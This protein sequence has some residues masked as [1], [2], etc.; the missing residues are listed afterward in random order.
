MIPKSGLHRLSHQFSTLSATRSFSRS[1]RIS[2]VNHED[3]PRLLSLCGSEGNFHLG[4]SL[5]ASIFKNPDFNGLEDDINSRNSLFIWNSLLYAYVKWGGM[6]NACNLFDDMPLKDTVSWNTLI[7]G[8]LR[9]GEFR[10][11]I[12]LFKRMQEMSRID[13]ATITTILS[14]CDRSELC[15]ITRM[16][17]GVVCKSGYEKE[18]TVRNALITSYFRCGVFSSSGKQVFDEMCEKNVISWT[19]LISGLAK[20]NFFAESLN[21]F[22]KMRKGIVE[23]NSLTYLSSITAC[24]GL[25]A[26]IEGRQIHGIVLK[27]GF[28]SN[29]C[30]ESA[31]M[32]MYSK[33]G[34]V[35]DAWKIFEFAETLDEISITVI[36]VGFAQNGLEEEALQIFIKMLRAGIKIDSNV[37]S[38]IL[39]VFG[40][41]S[42]SLGLGSQIH[43]LIIKRSMAPNPFIS[44]GL[45]NMY[46]K[47]GHLDDSIKVFNRMHLRNSI[48]YN[49]MIASLARHGNGPGALELYDKMRLEAVNPT[50][51]TFLSLLH[52]CSHVGL[53]DK[54]MEFLDSMER[55]Y[56]IKPRAEHY[57]CIVDMLGRAGLLYEAKIFIEQRM[58]VNP[59]SLVWQSFLGA[60][61]IHKNSD[62]G[63]YAAKQLTKLS[64]ESPVPYILMAN[65]FSSEGKWK[66]RA[67]EIKAMKEMGAM[68][69][70]GISWIEIEKE[71]HS[72]V[73]YDRMH[74]QSESVFRVLKELWWL[75]KDEGYVPDKRFILYCL[76][77]EE[78]EEGE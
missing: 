74:P 66:D 2:V 17:H 67:M 27:L 26:M 23:P 21:F 37:V 45:I 55:D 24:S 19:A 25:Q 12:F 62:L 77:D 34:S 28:E 73:V 36:L 69:E 68:K 31:L 54:G 52:A 18:V 50:D 78:D 41:G 75:L 22:V 35:M 6:A 60:C 49:S 10:T 42:S 1:S 61:S 65:I 40:L 56:G 11:C 8:Y 57:A 76:Q 47:C 44:N 43:A 70:T 5:H 29:L 32:D 53:V 72:F 64:P 4:S 71:V 38:A 46:S 48:S 7:S 15:N 3:I 20:N 51:V 16:I 59:D 14:G 13:K 63:K 58:P 39:G 9:Y 33:C 30:I